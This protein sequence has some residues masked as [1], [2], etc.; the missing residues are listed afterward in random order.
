MSV[1]IADPVVVLSADVLAYLFEVYFL[2]ARY[3]G[4]CA[5]SKHNQDR[6]QSPLSR[7]LK[8]PNNLVK[9]S[10]EICVE[11]VAQCLAKRVAL[12]LCV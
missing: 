9:I 5:K 4:C 11:N 7:H 6:G 12:R 2:C 8:L 3:I 10:L 1:V